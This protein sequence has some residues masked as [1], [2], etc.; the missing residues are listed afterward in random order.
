VT[1]LGETPA[2]TVM[3]FARSLEPRASTTV[4]R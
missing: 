3:Q 1:I 4:Q 2:E